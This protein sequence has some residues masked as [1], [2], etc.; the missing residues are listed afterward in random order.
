MASVTALSWVKHQ[1]IGSLTLCVAFS[2]GSIRLHKLSQEHLHGLSQSQ[3]MCGLETS[4]ACPPDLK[5]VTAMDAVTLG[6]LEYRSSHC[7]L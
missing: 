2:D 7:V 6:E 3:E 4:L 5:A 1:P